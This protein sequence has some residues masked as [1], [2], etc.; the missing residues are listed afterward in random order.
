MSFEHSEK[1]AEEMFV[2]LRQYPETVDRVEGKIT[3]PDK[4][5]QPEKLY[6][7]MLESGLTKGKLLSSSQ[8]S[9]VIYPIFS[10]ELFSN[11]I[12]WREQYWKQ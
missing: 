6:R 12:D 3:F 8:L 1:F 9:N 2:F 5:T 4:E 7:P 10:I 11:S